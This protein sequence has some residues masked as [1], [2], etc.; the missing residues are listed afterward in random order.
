MKAII[1][2]LL[3]MTGILSACSTTDNEDLVRFV[4]ESNNIT[5]SPIAPLPLVAPYVPN[6]YLAFSLV[7]PF[8]PRAL[9]LPPPYL[10]GVASG[11]N[12]NRRREPLENYPIESLKMVGVIKQ[13][14]IFAYVKTPDNNFFLVKR[15]GYLGKNYGH[16][17]QVTETAI[18][19]KEWV[20]DNNGNW[21]EQAK[22]L[23]LEEE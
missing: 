3:F 23:L 6:R 8:K 13:K 14:E 9:G 7:D 16:I 15:G 2:L 11:K 20:E 4:S 10:Q 21:E 17:L 1:T 22:Q 5:H 12:Q 18:K 19:F